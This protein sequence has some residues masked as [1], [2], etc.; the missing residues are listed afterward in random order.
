MS[1]LMVTS[2]YAGGR[3]F[4]RTTWGV[5]I[6]WLEGSLMSSLARHLVLPCEGGTELD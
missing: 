4:D 2:T 5:D 6:G 3:E 1:R